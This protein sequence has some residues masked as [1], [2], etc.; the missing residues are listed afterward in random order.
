MSASPFSTASFLLGK[1]PYWTHLWYCTLT[2]Q[3]LLVPW[4]LLSWLVYPGHHIPLVLSWTLPLCISW[5]YQK[6]HTFEMVLHLY[7]SC[8]SS[9]TFS[10]GYDPFL[11]NIN[12]LLTPCCSGCFSISA[13]PSRV[14]IFALSSRLHFI[15]FWI[16]ISTLTLTSDHH[17]TFHSFLNQS[18]L[19]SFKTQFSSSHSPPWCSNALAPQMPRTV[20]RWRMGPGNPTDRRYACI[21]LFCCLRSH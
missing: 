13:I 14:L 19:V 21:F 6:D 9:W 12:L 11:R 5:S 15:S 4:F 16:Y 2:Y 20:G 1:L 10:F 8:H 7:S 3:V 18:R 17:L